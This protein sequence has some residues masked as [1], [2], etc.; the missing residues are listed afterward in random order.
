MVDDDMSKSE[1][2]GVV[3]RFWL[4]GGRDA[5]WVDVEGIEAKGSEEGCGDRGKFGA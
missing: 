2:D 1:D 3:G 5:C 4:C